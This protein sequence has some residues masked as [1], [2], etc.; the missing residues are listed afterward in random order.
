[1][2]FFTQLY[3]L[4]TTYLSLD[5]WEQSKTL[6]GWATVVMFWFL[7]LMDREVMVPPG[8]LTH[9]HIQSGIPDIPAYVPHKR[10]HCERS[11]LDLEKPTFAF[12]SIILP[13]SSG[14]T[15]AI[16]NYAWLSEDW[17]IGLQHFL[18]FHIN[19]SFF[20]FMLFIN[21]VKLLLQLRRGTRKSHFWK[22]M[23]E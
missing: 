3:H 21:L 23:Q 6:F 1:M 20:I 14:F 2:V 11:N 12:L 4:R 7:Q 8:C 17:L 18:I 19:N 13:E 22:T 16:W 5:F 15:A 10:Q 9:C